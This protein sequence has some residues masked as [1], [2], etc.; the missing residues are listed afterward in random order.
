MAGR[1][2]ACPTCFCRAD[3]AGRGEKA[4]T[5]LCESFHCHIVKLLYCNAHLHL[6]D[7]LITPLLLVQVAALALGFGIIISS[8]TTKYRDLEVLVVWGEK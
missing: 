1:R 7:V 6:F 2:S 3:E 5:L 4:D 8:M